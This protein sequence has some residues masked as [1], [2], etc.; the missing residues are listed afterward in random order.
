MGTPRVVVF[1]HKFVAALGSLG[2]GIE[3]ELSPVLPLL[4][5]LSAT[6]LTDAHMTAGVL[7]GRDE[8]PRLKKTG[9]APLPPGAHLSFSS[10]IVD[11]DAP[12]ERKT[13]VGTWWGEQRALLEASPLWPCAWYQTRGGYRLVW[14]L[15][16]P[17]SSPAE[18]EE[19]LRRVHA[20]LAAAGLKTD[21]L[22]DWTRLYRLPFVVREGANERWDCDFSGL[23]P[24]PLASLLASVPFVSLGE[25]LV[26]ARTPNDSLDAEV[27]EA[28]KGIRN[29]NLF[30]FAR[31]LVTRAPELPSAVV[32]A[33]TEAMNQMKCSPPKPYD[34][35]C[36]IARN[37]MKYVPAAPPDPGAG[38]AGGGA[39]VTECEAPRKQVLL[40]PSEVGRA[41]RE[42]QAILESTAGLYQQSGVLVRL[43]RDIDGSL[44]IQELPKPS[45][46]VL[47]ENAIQF[48][49]EKTSKSGDSFFVPVDMPQVLVDALACAADNPV[50]EL[51]E[52]LTTPTLAPNGSLVA[53]RGYHADLASFMDPAVGVTAGVTRAE[54]VVALATLKELLVDFPFEN[55]AHRSVA[56]A[57]ILTP[58]VRSA[59]A[60]PI[61]LV[62]IDGTT[63]NSGKSLLADISAILVTGRDAPK[64]PLTGEEEFEKRVTALLQTG[65]RTVLIDNID[66]PLGGASLDALLTADTW[67]GR[68]LGSSRMIK[69][70]SR[71]Q[72]MATGNNVA[73]QGDVSRRAIR[74]FLAPE[75]ERPEERDDY[76]FPR[77]KE[78]VREHRARYVS[79][80]LTVVRAWMLSGDKVALPSMGSYEGWSDTVRS[81]LVWLG[82]ADPVATQTELRLDSAVGVWQTF[83]DACGN[84]YGNRPF[85]AKELFDALYR[86]ARKIGGSK[87]SYSALEGAMDELIPG[88]TPSV[89]GISA[90]LRR[91]AG[92]VVGGKKLM[93]APRDSVRGNLF[94]VSGG[95]GVAEAPGRGGVVA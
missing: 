94:R 22:L 69:L 72:W 2:E 84:I 51:Q 19:L 13:D 87:E 17:M 34:E 79:A 53:E 75:M 66:R 70:R 8:Q 48:M 41:L 88:N 60:G 56:L 38:A 74:C 68:V 61:P 64:Q 52:V 15:A 80:A 28:G 83:L 10:V 21:V 7:D 46:R 82:E 6:Y 59:I 18:Y 36:Q 76:A 12:D 78:H 40:A 30:S 47:V 11:G 9:D 54:A 62:I 90:L 58:V 23:S 14:E 43:N 65:V 71:A 44:S 89:R 37:A 95:S 81:A 57:T 67:T 29:K 42:C 1:A 3:P 26:S 91:W 63:P 24:L 92:R 77:M 31:L 85:S 35:V 50:P 27:W 93:K 39:T 16:E 86:G 32:L 55:P 73:I 45:L 5:A 25:S 4:D 20:T 49:N 33:L